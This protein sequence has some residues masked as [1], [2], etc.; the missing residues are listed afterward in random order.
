MKNKQ[1]CAI[2]VFYQAIMNEFEH[3]CFKIY[4]RTYFRED[5]KLVHS[6]GWAVELVR[7]AQ[8]VTSDTIGLK[9]TTGHA[10]HKHTLSRTKRTPVTS[11]GT[12]TWAEKHNLGNR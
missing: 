9:D 8:A 12:A 7:A 5:M 3:I 1:L 11:G 6:L 10:N 2:N 4:F